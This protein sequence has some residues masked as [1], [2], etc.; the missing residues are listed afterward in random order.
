MFYWLAAEREVMVEIAEEIKAAMVSLQ[1]ESQ[2]SS[3]APSTAV[4]PRETSFADFLVRPIEARPPDQ[5]GKDT[6]K[7]SP[8]SEGKPVGISL[9]GFWHFL[10]NTLR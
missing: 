8:T 5:T 10:R 4:C 7:R 6:N 2:A 3:P 9:V 1:S